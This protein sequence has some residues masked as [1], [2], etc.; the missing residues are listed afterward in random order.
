M[1]LLIIQIHILEDIDISEN[2]Q[3]LLITNVSLLFSLFFPYEVSENKH[4][5]T[6]NQLQIFYL[7][8]F[9]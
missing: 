5:Y 6:S 2:I 3:S 1:S 4:A 8:T 7:L 9:K